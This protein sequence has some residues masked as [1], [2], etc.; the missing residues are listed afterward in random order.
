MLAVEG[1]QQQQHQQQASFAWLLPAL[2]S[3]AAAGCQ[4]VC[5]QWA[6]PVNQQPSVQQHEHTLCQGSLTG[7]SSRMLPHPAWAAGLPPLFAPPSQEQPDQ[8]SPGTSGQASQTQRAGTVSRR[9]LGLNQ[10]QRRRT[11][12]AQARRLR[13]HEEEGWSTDS[14]ESFSEVSGAGTVQEEDLS[15]S[16]HSS[17]GSQQTSSSALEVRH[18]HVSLSKCCGWDATSR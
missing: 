9:K 11:S 5:P 8:A 18:G 7:F 3:A 6:N 12:M 13:N 17:Q 16:N 4:F 14:C 10:P 15:E 2:G 1:Q